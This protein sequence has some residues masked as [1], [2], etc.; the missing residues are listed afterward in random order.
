MQD[1]EAGL[2]R[3]RRK[4]KFRASHRGIKEMDL[5]LGHY[6]E[7]AVDLMG[8]EELEEFEALLELHDRDLMQWF[9]GEVEVPVEHRTALFQKIK[10]NQLNIAKIS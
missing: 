6:A 9:T 5:I 8:P 4:L 3:L 10:Q 1:I 2:D 7:S